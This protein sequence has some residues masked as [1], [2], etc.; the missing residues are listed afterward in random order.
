M[1]LA[2]RRTATHDRR[3]IR[4]VV[5]G[6][7]IAALALS[8]CGGDDATEPT[9]ADESST[10][11]VEAG[12]LFYEPSS[13]R[14]TAGEIEVT[15]DNTGAIEHDLIIEEAGDL[16]AV[17]MVAPGDTATGTVE[18]DAGTYTVYCSVPGHRGGGMEATL[19]VS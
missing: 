6:L 18:L 15:L 9:A 14:T 13:L 19:E 12:D 7:A 2:P 11:T 4:R 10:L 16:D 8:A 17:G 5:A 1:D 3:P